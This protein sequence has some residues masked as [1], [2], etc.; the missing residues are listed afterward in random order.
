VFDP[1]KYAASKWLKGSDLQAGQQL[2][3]TIKGGREHQFESETKPVISFME[4]DSE[5]VLNKTQMKTLMDLFGD[6]PN[7]WLGQSVL[8]M[9]I[10]SGYP[11]KPSILITTAPTQAPSAIGH[12]LRP[13]QPPNPDVLFGS[14]Q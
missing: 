6:D 3:V 11:G 9:P 1:N 14:R 7:L 13:Q 5:M 8:L 4:I 10:P 2:R 12:G